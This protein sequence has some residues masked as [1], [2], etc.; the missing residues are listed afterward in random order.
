MLGGIKISQFGTLAAFQGDSPRSVLCVN[1]SRDRREDGESNN[2]EACDH[3]D[4]HA[5]TSA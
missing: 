3:V 4:T 2:R 5:S 1:R